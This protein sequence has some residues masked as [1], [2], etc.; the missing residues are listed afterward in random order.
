MSHLLEDLK[1]SLRGLRQAPVLTGIVLL[2]IAIGIGATTAIYSVVNAVVLQPLAYPQAGQLVSVSTQ[3]PTMGFDRFWVSPPEYFE[4]SEWSTTLATI[5]AYRGGEVSVVGTEEPL[6]NRA[7]FATATLFEVLGA[8][9]YRGRLWD[10][11]SDRPGAEAVAVLSHEL[12]QSQFGGR[13]DVLGASLE[14]DGMPTTLVGVLPP[15]F[16][17]AEERPQLWIPLTLDPAN[18]ENR[19]NH[20]LNLVARLH[21]G[22]TLEDADAELATLVAGWEERTG[23]GHNPSPEGH[24]M[25]VDALKEVVVG[26]TRPALL[27]LLASVGFVLLIASVNV[28][29]L[30]LARSESR[31]KEIAVRAAVGATRARLVRQLLTESVLLAFVGGALGVAVAHRGLALLLR[32]FPTSLPRTQE[33]SLDL[34]VLTVTTLTAA[35]TGI[36]FGLAPALSLGRGR[37]GALL[38]EGGRR[39]S[40]SISSLRL[41]RMLVV[42]EVAL[43]VGLVFGA[44]LMMRSLSGLVGLDA[45]FDRDRLFTYEL[46][47]PSSDYPAATDQ[48]AFLGRL[49]DELQK[50]PGIDRAAAADG[51]PPSRDLNANDME[52]E[53]VERTEDGPVHNMDYWQFASTDYL[54]TLGIRVL[55]GRGFAA[56]D[57]GQATPVALIN[58]R[59]AEVF[60]PDQDPVGRRL[61]PG[62]GD[63]PWFTIVGVVEDVKQR[64]LDAEVGTEVYWHAEQVGEAL[65]R[66]PRSMHVIVQSG[67][68]QATVAQALRETTWRLD[69]KLPVASV[70][71]MEAVVRDTLARQR[72]LTLLL[73]L[74]AGIALFL[75]AIGV[76][77][78]MSY[79]VELR[80]RELGLRMALGAAP[81]AILRLVLAQGALLTSIG[82]AVGLAFSFG[83]ARLLRSLLFGVSTSDPW[84]FALVL[85]VLA[86]AAGLATSIPAWRATRI[87]PQEALH[88][89]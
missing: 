15:N 28:A 60:Y 37:F 2:T 83:F 36:L 42:A 64:G 75:A 26:D 57:D 20:F 54:E 78:V 89:E 40:A 70:Q 48:L 17:I 35:A 7:V 67:L 34:P 87:A 55:S 18:R 69:P 79:S 73:L 59:A 8:Q 62:F 80:Q 65:G 13:E 51:L 38:K 27:A 85:L 74:F 61:R 52:F 9:P 88:S 44:G 71:P 12:W 14:I 50:V 56:T 19:G 72:L 30:L 22:L 63:M 77:G 29:N 84:A 5:G 43:A 4:L 53:G 21:P 33:V 49:F 47:L 32:A 25:R 11:E 46:Y 76:Y 6:R 68:D 31:Q 10:S 45:G 3:F 23:A 1:V 24:P 41:R 66:M 39:A 86:V 16:D 58:Q 82:L 81:A